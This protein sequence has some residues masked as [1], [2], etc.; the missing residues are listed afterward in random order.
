[1]IGVAISAFLASHGYLAVALLVGLESIGIP[2]PGETALIAAAVLAGASGKLDIGLP[3]ATGDEEYL[4]ALQQG[5]HQAFDQ[6]VPDLVI[7]LAGA[8]PFEG[9]RL[10]RL[11]LTKEGLLARDRM[12]FDVCQQKRIPTAITMAGGYARNVH[13]MVDIQFNTISDASKRIG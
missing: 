7:Y 10:G 5:L 13:D 2:L 1:M 3:D 9:D 12:V 8:D 6:F 4:G 11:K